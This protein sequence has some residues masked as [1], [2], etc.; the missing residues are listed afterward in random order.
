[1]SFLSSRHTRLS[2][3]ILLCTVFRVS[4]AD[5]KQSATVAPKTIAING[6]NYTLHAINGGGY[7]MGQNYTLT[8]YAALAYLWDGETVWSVDPLRGRVL[9]KF[10]SQFQVR[11]LSPDKAWALVQIKTGLALMNVATQEITS[12]FTGDENPMAPGKAPR[13]PRSTPGPDNLARFHQWIFSSN[14]KFI[15]PLAHPYGVK[16]YPYIDAV[17]KSVVEVPLFAS[18]KEPRSLSGIVG[19]DGEGVMLLAKG[20]THEEKS[21]RIDK[22]VRIPLDNPKRMAVTPVPAKA[23]IRQIFAAGDNRILCLLD[24]SYLVPDKI[25]G[26]EVR[27]DDYRLAWLDA[28]TFKTIVFS[29]RLPGGRIFWSGFTPNG[30]DIYAIDDMQ[31]LT[32]HD[33]RTLKL[34]TH[35]KAGRTA[36]AYSIGAT[37]SEDGK[38]AFLAQPYAGTFDVVDVATRKVSSKVPLEQGIAGILPIGDEC[39]VISTMLPYE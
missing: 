23:N 19:F 37:F 13:N 31:G 10:P 3:L 17:K 4:L 28:G 24:Q 36:N 1:M 18:E 32:I 2:I 21:V 30:K 39:F 38:F 11:A 22:L 16:T 25:L 8:G 29:P 20:R 26:G 12:T 27:K 9:Q 14:G 35:A 33:A 6:K 5:E 15:Y 7:G 34:I